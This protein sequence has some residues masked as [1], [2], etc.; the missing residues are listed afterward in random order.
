MKK[1]LKGA[2]AALVGGA[3]SSVAVAAADPTGMN[4]VVLGKVAAIGALTHLAMFLKHP[5]TDE[6]EVK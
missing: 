1:F 4:I 6:P 3:V 5:G 2:L